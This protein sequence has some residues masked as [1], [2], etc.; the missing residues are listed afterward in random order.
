MEQKTKRFDCLQA[1]R[2]IA[3]LMIIFC[4]TDYSSHGQTGVDFFFVISGFVIMLS[5]E[6]PFTITSFAVKRIKRIVPLYW[7]VTIVLSVLIIFRPQLFRTSVFSFEYLMKSLFFI[8]YLQNGHGG[9]IL[10]IA[11]TL[12]M[13]VFF[14]F[15]F[16]L[17]S[18][19]SR[20]YRG[21]IASGL[22]I[23]LIVIISKANFSYPIAFW[24]S[25]VMLEFVWGIAVYYV[26]KYIGHLSMIKT[27]NRSQLIATVLFWLILISGIILMEANYKGNMLSR[28]YKVGLIA[29]AIVMISV[30]LNDATRIP[31]FLKCLGDNCYEVYL[32][33]LFLIRLLT[34]II[35]KA[36]GMNLL[37]AMLAMA[38]ALI[39]LNVMIWAIH[40]LS[41]AI[42]L[43]KNQ[44]SNNTGHT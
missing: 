32:L 16:G 33:H 25:P 8:P 39:L 3:C 28:P 34:T 2:A 42:H 10:A 21:L 15:I 18:V 1:I 5:T 12:N 23:M 19:I 43:N 7:T 22:I 31:T 14:Y 35:Y 37:S 38:V 11:W 13:E 24:G 4:H 29:A 40:R 36:M 27:V 9:P 20:K 6:K 41:M 26:W 44:P 30:L 17:S